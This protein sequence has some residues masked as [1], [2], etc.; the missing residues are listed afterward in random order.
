[1][2]TIAEQLKQIAR[3]EGRVRGWEEGCM[4]GREESEAMLARQLTRRFGPLP[5]WARERLRRSDAAQREAWADAVL[6][7]AS[8]V[9]VIG[10]PPD[11]H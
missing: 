7:A 6:D 3:E 1:M 8:L 9:E 4:K 11:S 2:M 5:E 10:A